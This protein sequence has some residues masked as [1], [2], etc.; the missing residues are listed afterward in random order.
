MSNETITGY[1]KHGLEAQRSGNLPLALQFYNDILEIE[2][3]NPAANFNTGLIKLEQSAPNEA[4]TYFYRAISNRPDIPNFWYKYIETLILLN[5]IL[6][7]NEAIGQTKLFRVY[8]DYISKLERKVSL[9]S[10]RE[11][12]DSSRKPAFISEMLEPVIKKVDD[13]CQ[14]GELVTAAFL[15]QSTLDKH[16]KNKYV[17]SKLQSIYK[18]I[19]KSDRKTSNPPNSILIELQRL[20]KK[21]E[22]STALK[23]INILLSQFRNSFI[24]YN[25]KGLALAKLNDFNG[26]LLCF[27]I[28][29]KQNRN[30]PDA[31]T[32]AGNIL[33]E[34]KDIVQAE[35]YLLRALRLNPK[36]VICLNNLGRLYNTS[37]RFDLAIT[38]FNDAIKVDPT[39]PDLFNNLGNA[40]RNK[41]DNEKAIQNYTR[42]T[43]LDPDHIRAHLNIGSVF[44]KL[45]L[46]SDSKKAY[47]TVLNIDH[48]NKQA[49]NNLG[50]VN[51]YLGEPKKAADLFE[52]AL[53]SD[54][55][56]ST[57]YSNLL[58]TIYGSQLY[59]PSE[60]FKLAQG[61][62]ECVDRPTKNHRNKFSI[63]PSYT[64]IRI[65]LVS[66]DLHDHPVSYFLENLVTSINKNKYEIVVF[67]NH[68]KVTNETLRIKKHAA[69][70]HQIDKLDDYD[71]T[72]LIIKN[73][74]SILIDLSGHTFRNRLPVFAQKPAKIQATWLGYWATTGLSE[75]DFIIADR[76]LVPPS[77]EIYFTEK[78]ARLPNSYL[79]FVPPPF[80][81]E[82]SETPAI[83]NNFITFGCFNNAIKISYDV[84][85]A[86]SEIL[87]S[88]PN[89]KIYFKGLSYT[90]DQ[91][92]RISSIFSDLK[93][94]K[95]RIVFE[96]LSNREEIL[97]SYKEVDIALDTF[98][99]PGGTTSCEAL[100]MGVPI[101]STK[102]N[103]FLSNVS[104]SIFHAAN[105]EELFCLTIEEYI[106][107]AQDLASDYSKLNST[108]LKRRSIL[109]ASDL[110]N[111]EKFAR[112]FEALC[113]EMIKIND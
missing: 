8:D 89:S 106:S 1:L 90:E 78:V 20:F 96:G 37:G 85:E 72:N 6:K 33:V 22:I 60:R 82:V 98:P 54:S 48:S 76:F 92:L 68:D 11:H 111:G 53:L 12:N 67:S 93:I 31:Y 47:Q 91:K 29:I 13:L 38:H 94:T 70:W 9:R 25:L 24:L 101:I 62:N 74:I 103:D 95:E 51:L 88:T 19:T 26:A 86:W 73:N 2:L 41:N 102:G 5:D 28:A 50:F 27:K 55:K 97:K 15:L 109:E 81:I 10:L 58:F 23:H 21:T 14:K 46:F 107:K 34:K 32:N 71:V 4:V 113:T 36:S 108:R 43:E 40:W 17:K 84:V 87:I 42:A 79:C 99:Y 80:E 49:L 45:R 64:K 3:E 56:D 83:K 52:Q 18:L 100:W 16:P 65:G 104:E 57:I 63:L 69:A 44:S 39:V 112:S 105:C 30:F 110:C 59:T 66:G 77:Q 61:F 75:V 7:V 35:K